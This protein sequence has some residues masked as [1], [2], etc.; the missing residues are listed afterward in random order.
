M[1]NSPSF[2]DF[3]SKK[4]VLRKRYLNAIKDN[5]LENLIGNTVYLYFKDVRQIG[6]TN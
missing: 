4:Y 5:S 6:I 2:K 1:D 3:L